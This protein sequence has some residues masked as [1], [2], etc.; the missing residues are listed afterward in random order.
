M[1]CYIC[2][3]KYVFMGKVILWGVRF[4]ASA[5]IDYAVNIQEVELKK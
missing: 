5:V 2:I 3:A 4:V 1:L